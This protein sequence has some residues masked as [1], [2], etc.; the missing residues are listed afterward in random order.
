MNVIYYYYFLFYA[1][2]LKDDEPHLLTTMA[3]SASEG[4]ALSVTLSI[5][6]IKFFCFEMTNFLMFLPT[7]L[8]LLFNYFFFYKSGKAI[9][10]TKEKPM[11]F[12]NHKL[13]VIITLLFFI[14]TLSFMFWG[15]IYTK[16][17]LET[18]CGS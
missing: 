17:L 14:I 10:I 3:L 5:L 1:K 12:L 7:C 13:S 18:Y 8:F 11:F 2:V 16:Y 4:F 9:E 15:P 6:L